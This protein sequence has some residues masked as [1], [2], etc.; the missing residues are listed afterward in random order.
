M[1]DYCGW[2]LSQIKI[3]LKLRKNVRGPVDPHPLHFRADTKYQR[4]VNNLIIA[5]SG[6]QISSMPIV[7]T[8]T[9]ANPFA[10][11]NAHHYT[12][13]NYFDCCVDD[14][15]KITSLEARS[16]VPSLPV[17]RRAIFHMYDV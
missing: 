16:H 2:S 14:I 1:S 5:F 9:P 8:L 17:V 15:N 12:S 3:E 13:R 10:I 7:Q 6:T 4:F 11:N